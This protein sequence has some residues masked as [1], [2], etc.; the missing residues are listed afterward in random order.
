MLQ[1]LCAEVSHTGRISPSMLADQELV[2]LLFTPDSPKD[3]RAA[4]RG[5]PDDACSWSEIYC[6][7]A[8]NITEI[9]WDRTFIE[10][11]GSMNMQFLPQKL[12]IFS[13][14]AQPIRGTI[15]TSSLPQTMRTLSIDECEIS[16]TVDLG[17]LPPR[18]DSIRIRDN[19]ITAIENVCNL[20]L[21]MRTLCVQEENIVSKKLHIGVLPENGRA[22]NFI[23][24]EL[25]DVTFENPKD[26]QRVNL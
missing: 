13:L 24:C 6:D 10:L 15:D 23:G 14:Y 5:D 7:E 18:I 22:I 11:E 9:S 17:N 25:T 12:V 21:S 19:K 2:E 26:V 8:K 16:G 4:F 3:S 1:I 20:P